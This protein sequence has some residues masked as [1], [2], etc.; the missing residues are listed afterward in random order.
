VS[1][2]GGNMLIKGGMIVDG[3]GSAP[4]AADLRISGGRIVEIGADL[5]AD[6]VEVHDAAGCYVTPGFIDSHTHYDGSL[7]WDPACDPILQHGVTTVL[8][9]NCSLGL[10]PVRKESIGD[11]ATLFSYI[12]DLPR[13]TF[14]NEIPW[15]WET[16]GE[17]ADDMR[18]RQFGVNVVALVSHSLLRGY[19][20]GK[21]AWSRASTGDEVE[22]IAANYDAALAAGAYGISSSRFDRSPSGDLVPSFYADATELDRIFAVTAKHKGIFQIIPDMGSLDQQEKD[23]RE[24]C[25]YSVRNARVPVI[26]NG[27]YQRPDDPDY[28]PR[29]LQ[30]A[31]EERAKG[32]DFRFLASPRSIELLVSFHQAMVFIYVPS[33]NAVV[34]PGVDME[35]KRRRLADPA[36]REQA[37]A[38]WDAVKEGFPSGG[39]IR[40]FRIVKAGKPE[41]ERYVGK[42]F[43]VVLDERGGH[44]SDVLA[45]WVLDNDFEPEFVFP[46]TNTDDRIV[47]QLLAAEESI[48]SASD[49]GAH[50]GMF[51]GAGDTTLVLTRHV[52]DSAD[53]T[54]ETAVKRMTLEQAELLGLKDRG[55]I[56]QGAIADIAVFDLAELHWDVEQKVF[57]VPGGKPRFRRPVGGMRYTFVNGVLAQKDGELTGQLAARFLDSRDREAA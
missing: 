15:K 17:Y 4:Y 12:E 55:V 6:G 13:D 16:F 51:D 24:Y 40:G 47:G 33:W 31:K 57:D 23:L 50:I 3:T 34:Q 11:L 25:G 35:E 39:M 44:P 48:I 1:G 7:Y 10:A 5:S 49:A 26:S 21:A 37:R 36:W 56:R 30:M 19:E 20:L 8:I 27:I 22:R 53:M 14:E 29:L 46:F 41:N 52:R 43:D 54:L 2:A 28:H 45:D 18:S 9:G 32:A 38:D 42:T